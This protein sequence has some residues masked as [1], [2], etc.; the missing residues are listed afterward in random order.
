MN[1]QVWTF[2]ARTC[3]FSLRMK[4][5][6]H[7]HWSRIR[8]LRPEVLDRAT[9]QDLTVLEHRDVRG[10]RHWHP[11][12]H[13]TPDQPHS[14]RLLQRSRPAHGLGTAGA[15]SDSPRSSRP[16]FQPCRKG[17]QP[18]QGQAALARAPATQVARVRTRATN[19]VIN[20]FDI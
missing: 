8:A 18:D 10:R 5:G 16:Q 12:A 2:T 13:S 20:S 3:T 6:T 15:D 19:S 14:R 9:I 1:F 7:D 17:V 11:G 4:V